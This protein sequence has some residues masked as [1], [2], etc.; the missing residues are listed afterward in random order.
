MSAK[1][2]KL[3]KCKNC[4]YYDEVDSVRCGYIVGEE[5]I[6]KY[7]DEVIKAAVY[8][9]YKFNKNGFC[10]HYTKVWWKFWIR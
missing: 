5:I 4:I 6:S 3:K 7:T 2:I 8:L 10:K 1:S 9:P